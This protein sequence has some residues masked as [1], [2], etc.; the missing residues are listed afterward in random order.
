MAEKG[1]LSGGGRLS[2]VFTDLFILTSTLRKAKDFGDPELLR[3]R[4]IEMFDTA[5]SQGKGAGIS[6]ESMQQARYALAALLDETILSSQWTYKDNW[7][8]NPLQYQ[9]F[10]EHL[11]G[12]E[13]YNRLDGIRKVL[14][15]NIDLLEVYY[16][17]FIMG[18]EGQYKLHGREKLKAIVEEIAKQ[19]KDARGGVLP[20]SPHGKRPEEFIEVVKSGLPTWVVVVSLAAIVFFFYLTLSYMMDRNAG[21]NLEELKKIDW[22][23]K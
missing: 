21:R 6:D 7:F 19:I 12:V 15:L 22:S 8:S 10:Q 9:F 18:F 3:R 23:H 13:F 17:C 1:V 4:I 16:L 20:L 2:E 14:P 11:A 5:S